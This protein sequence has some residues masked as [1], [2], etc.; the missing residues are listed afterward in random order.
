M[1]A[2]GETPRTQR[3]NDVV[4]K[5]KAGERRE[6]D[7]AG[8]VALPA[9]VEPADGVVVHRDFGGVGDDLH[10]HRARRRRERVVEHRAR[11]AVRVRD[12]VRCVTRIAAGGD[13]A[14]A[15][16]R[17]PPI[18]PVRQPEQA[19]GN[20]AH[21]AIWN[22]SDAEERRDRH[23]TVD[24]V[25]LTDPGREQ[26]A[27]GK[28]GDG[29]AIAEF[30][31]DVD[32]LGY[33]LI[34]FFGSE[35]LQRREQPIGMTVVRQAWHD[36]VVAALEQIDGDAFELRRARAESVQQDDRA[37]APLA[38]HV[39]A[40]AAVLGDAGVVARN[41]LVE[42]VEAGGQEPVL[43]TIWVHLLSEQALESIAREER[44]GAHNYDPLPL[45]VERAQG[46]WLWD[47]AGRRYLDCV[48]AYSAINQGHC[49]PRIYEAMLQQARRVTLTSRA[50]HNDRM[51]ALLEHLT[52]VC[53]YDKALL[54]NTGVEAV[55][56]AVKLARRWGYRVK[57]IPKD[58]ARIVVFS[59]NFHGR[60]IAAV[61]ASTTPEYRDA[62]GPFL[63]GFVAV[64]FGDADALERAL[65]PETCAVL[66]E[67][68]QGEGGVNV[69]P[70]G[71]LKRVWALCREHEIL[72]LADEVQTGFGRTGDLFACDDEG[73]KPDV[74]IVG[75][76]LGGGFYPVSAALANDALMNL[77]E[78]GDHGSTFGGNPLACA[79]A[80][81]ALDVV[82]A[83]NLPARARYAG[84]AITQGLRAI[85]SP[86]V[87]EIRG[88]GLLI[89]LELTVP[90]ARLAEALLERGVVCKE[91]REFVLRVAPPLVIED[92]AI[93]YLLERFA[94]A[95]AAVSAHP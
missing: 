22:Y 36:N 24:F 4:R 64:P 15:Q 13:V 46:V 41:E 56:T 12:R 94:E 37:R 43:N 84:A 92:D 33:G 62:F 74:L 60:T 28:T 44:Y 32:V 93:A 34:E 3:R 14:V 55:E 1:D 85:G 20:G 80:D 27:Q 95:A 54:M 67:P 7:V 16:N 31:R 71:Y 77:F 59:N 89:G 87:K 26:S 66:V 90:A 8:T 63:P 49:H 35:P 21:Q 6:L 25:F 83:E 78:P 61:S 47:V 39:G 18:E 57:G 45:V 40:R 23:A 58:T 2:V 88:R 30:A 79:V 52:R 81:A 70:S 9:P 91:T 5:R 76:A 10:V 38:V 69:P 29:D 17:I 68:I 73:V 48:S 65:T 42:A 11:D 72:L 86:L 75:K 50:M 51:P 82:I 53:G 19:L